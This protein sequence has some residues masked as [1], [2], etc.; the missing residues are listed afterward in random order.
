M[1][2]NFH[3]HTIHN[4]QGIET[5]QVPI[6]YIYIYIYIYMYYI[7]LIIYIIYIIKKNDILPFSA[8]WMDLE[9]IKLSQRKTNII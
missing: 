4:S 9:S 3:S 1:P 2:P 6:N 5:T 8:T 7:I